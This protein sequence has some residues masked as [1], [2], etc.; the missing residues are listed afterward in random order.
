VLQFYRLER[1]S[2]NHMHKLYSGSSF[3]NQFYFYKLLRR[4]GVSFPGNANGYF[5]AH[6]PNSF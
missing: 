4:L 2:P 1:F 5:P 6:I 3:T